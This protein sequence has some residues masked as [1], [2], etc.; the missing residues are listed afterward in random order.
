MQ[1]DQ[2]LR[3]GLEFTGMSIL[4]AFLIM[5]MIWISAI[6]PAREDMPFY[7]WMGVAT[8]V[9]TALRA[10]HC[11]RRHLRNRKRAAEAKR[12]LRSARNRRPANDT[13]ATP[14]P[15]WAERIV[16]NTPEPTTAVM[17]RIADRMDREAEERRAQEI[18]SRYRP[19][20]LCRGNI[21]G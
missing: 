1:L 18:A 12:A 5:L 21:K 16:D 17:R 4:M 19:P 20:T 14:R 7:F 10:Y 15:T 9:I 8:C 6:G 3:D 11:W 2:N 13:Q